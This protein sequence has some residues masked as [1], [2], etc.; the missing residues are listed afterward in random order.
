MLE[1][2]KKKQSKDRE[3]RRNNHQ[4]E[5]QSSRQQATAL[6]TMALRLHTHSRQDM[7]KTTTMTSPLPH[8][9]RPLSSSH[10]HH[11]VPSFHQISRCLG[12]SD[13][14]PPPKTGGSRRQAANPSTGGA[15]SL[16]PFLVFFLEMLPSSWT[17]M[18]YSNGLMGHIYVSKRRYWATSV[19]PVTSV[20]KG[21]WPN[22]PN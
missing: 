16:L 9:R 3:Y 11:L 20:G 10:S 18:C 4:R 15:A 2:W 19:C 21:W 22:K 13:L 12:G 7:S 8:R 6:L 14:A 5:R 1:I 17:Y